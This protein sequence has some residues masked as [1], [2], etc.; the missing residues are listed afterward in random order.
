VTLTADLHE[1]LIR[2][3]VDYAICMLDPDGYVVSWNPGAERIK[4][5]SAQEISGN[6]FL[7]SILKRIMPRVFLGRP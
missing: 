6:T 4:G 5:Y 7:V 1:L 3:V 2:S